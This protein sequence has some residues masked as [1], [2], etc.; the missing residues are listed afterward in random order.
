MP[1][2]KKKA[3]FPPKELFFFFAS[4]VLARAVHAPLA[5][6]SMAFA[7]NS[8]AIKLEGFGETKTII[9]RINN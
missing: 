8:Q 1:L 7:E 4:Q 2:Q 5:M 6:R 3:D 9:L